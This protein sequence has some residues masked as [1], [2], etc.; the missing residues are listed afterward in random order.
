MNS[1]KENPDTRYDDLP[2]CFWIPLVRQQLHPLVWFN[3]MAL[4][5]PYVF[6]RAHSRKEALKA[7]LKMLEAQRDNF[8]NL[9][10]RHYKT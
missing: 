8:A 4:H 1:R 5:R 9:S 10:P 6:T 7:S 3:F 2:E